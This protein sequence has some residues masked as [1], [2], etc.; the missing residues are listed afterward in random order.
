MWSCLVDEYRRHGDM[1]ACTLQLYE[2]TQK[3]AVAKHLAAPPGPT[4]GPKSG[5]TSGPRL[6][7]KPGPKSGLRSEP[8]SEPRSRSGAEVVAILIYIAA[9]EMRKEV[10][11]NQQRALS[12]YMKYHILIR[13]RHGIL[14]V[15]Q[16]GEGVP[17]PVEVRSVEGKEKEKRRL[18]IEILKLRVELMKNLPSSQSEADAA[19]SRLQALQAS[20]HIIT[21]EVQELKQ[22]M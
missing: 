6:G 3:G 8:R 11:P 7:P 20:L 19:Q 14:F 22:R 9:Q 13:Q 16:Q 1:C 2:E 15:L 17:A 10:R 5:P 4:S 18:D 12:S 21:L